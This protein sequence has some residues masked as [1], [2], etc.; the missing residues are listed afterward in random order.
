MS[1]IPYPSTITK[2]QRVFVVDGRGRPVP[3]QVARSMWDDY[4]YE[5]HGIEWIRSDENG[6][7]VIPEH[8]FW[9]PLIYRIPRTLL[10]D[11]MLMAH[12]SVGARGMVNI[13]SDSCSSELYSYEP[14]QS[15]PQT[16][17]LDCSQ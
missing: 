4:T 2:E 11:L 5:I 3:N 9:A 10:A 15:L 1:F 17:V 7:V 13:G 16:I 14:S 8:K 6:A 12:G